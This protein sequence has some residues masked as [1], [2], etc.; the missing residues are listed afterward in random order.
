MRK[1]ILL[2]TLLLP[3]LS[4]C[5]FLSSL[6]AQDIHFS[7]FLSSPMNLNPALAGQFD[8]DHRFVMNH[9]NQWSSVTVP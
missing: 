3:L 7:Q 5:F 6:Q 9:R 2:G 1:F 4:A 8:G